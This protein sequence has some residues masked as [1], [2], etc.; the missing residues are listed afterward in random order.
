MREQ[1]EGFPVVMELPVVWGEMDSFG[2][3][4]NIVY[5]RYFESARITYFERIGYLETIK[6]T[7]VGPILASTCCNFKKALTFPDKI[8][9]GAKISEMS[10]D[11]FRM[12]YRIVSEKLGKIAAEGDGWIVS[13]NY[14]EGRK[15]PVPP[16]IRARIEALE[17]RSFT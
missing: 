9:V 17:E 13:F 15:A 14:R 8:Y 3:V 11:R 12:Q 2:H 16:E 4:N 5:F 1:I 10:E 6:T 7:G